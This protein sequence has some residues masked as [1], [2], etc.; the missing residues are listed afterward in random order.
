MTDNGPTA[1]KV[2]KK[3]TQRLQIFHFVGQ[4]LV[5]LIKFKI[6]SCS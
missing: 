5:M 4:T 2:I 3:K 6:Y 1:E